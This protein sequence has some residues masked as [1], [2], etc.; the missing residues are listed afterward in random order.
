M[1]PCIGCGRDMVEAL[2]EKEHHHVPFGVDMGLS[3]CQTGVGSSVGEAL[4]V[5]GTW[6]RCA[7][8]RAIVSCS[9]WT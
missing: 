8:G 1:P 9:F 3:G 2:F 4:V 5:S 6:W 7:S